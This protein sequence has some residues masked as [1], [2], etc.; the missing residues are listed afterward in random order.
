MAADLKALRDL[1]GEYEPGSWFLCHGR[2]SGFAPH[3]EGWRPFILIE[4]WARHPIAFAYPRSTT[5]R[6]GLNHRPHDHAREYPNCCISRP[7]KIL[8]I[9]WSLPAQLICSTNFSC[10]EPDADVVKAVRR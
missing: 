10:I 7:G 1:L 6:E 5:S 9:Q 4:R 8:W 3:K 2:C